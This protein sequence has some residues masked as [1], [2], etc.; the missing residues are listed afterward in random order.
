M[1]VDPAYSFAFTAD[2][3]GGD[4]LPAVKACYNQIAELFRNNE[5]TPARVEVRVWAAP[6]EDTNG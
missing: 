3:K 4:A 1:R 6:K 2:V 5:R